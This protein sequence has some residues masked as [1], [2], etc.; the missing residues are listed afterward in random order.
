MVWPRTDGVEYDVEHVVVD[1]KDALLVVHNDGAVNFELVSVAA[2]DP[3]G[4]RSVVLP[5]NPAG[6]SWASTLPRLWPSS[7]YRRGG[8]A[9]LGLLDDAT[10]RHVDELSFD[11]P[12][13]SVGTGGNPEWEPPLLRLGYGSF[14]TPATVY[15]F[16][17]ATGELRLR[18]RQP[19]L[20]DYDPAD[21]AQAREWAT[22]AGRH[23]HPD[24]A[25]VRQRLVRRRGRR[26]PT[27]LYGYGSYEHSIDPGFG[28]PAVA[29]RPRH[30]LRG[31]ARARRRR[32]GPAL[33]RGRQ[34]APQAQHVHRLRRRRAAPHRRRLHDRPTGWSPR[35][36]APAAC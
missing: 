16:V 10:R 4:E 20:G 5:H 23:A 29:A 33:V 18:K 22:A 14:V 6:D 30:D 17:V 9:R 11:E 34:D 25:R 32:D 12:L 21:Y 1:G 35:A 13:F 36:A 28:P 24:L 26:A 8:I 3:S 15:D 19:V 31:R 7:A 2:S 27:L